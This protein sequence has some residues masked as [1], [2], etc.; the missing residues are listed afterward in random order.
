MRYLALV[1]DFDNTLAADGAVSESTEEAISRLKASG[2]R[3]IIATGRLLDDLLAKWPRASIADCI[4]AENGGLIYEPSARETILLAEP[5]PSALV[6][7]LRAANGEHRL[8][9]GRTI[10]G[11]DAERA[12]DVIQVVRGLGLELQLV[13]NRQ[14]LMILPGGVNKALGVKFA[15]RRLGMSPHEAVGIGDAENDHSFLKLSECSAAVANAVPALKERVDIVTERPAGDGVAELIDS[16]VSEDLE[17]FDNRLS[18]H[19]VALGERLDGTTVWVPPYGRN[20]LVAGPSGSGKSTFVTG[21]MERLTEQFYQLCI[22][23]PEGDY[24]TLQLAVTLGDTKRVPTVDEALA[25]L[26]D[27][28]THLNLDLLGVPLADRPRYLADL[29]AAL[30]N[31]RVRTGRPHWIVIDEAHHVLPAG[32]G[33][34][35]SVLPRRLGETVLVTVRPSELARQI[36]PLIDV[37]VAVG[38]NADRTL[39]EFCLAAGRSPT[40]WDAVAAGQGDVVCWFVHGGQDPFPMKVLRGQSERLRHRRKYAEGDLGYKSFVFRGP[41]GSLKLKAQNLALFCQIAEGV[42]DATWQYHLRNGDYSHWFGKAVKNPELAAVVKDIER[43][44]DLAPARSRELVRAE[45][46]ARY[47]LPA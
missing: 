5:V 36:L 32:S 25:V 7:A 20:V 40:R 43:Q 15:L 46:E 45:I 34:S 17:S 22:V 12:A 14:A 42:D 13:F 37:V 16:L 23:D 2:R 24:A 8:E 4:V 39:D 11:T 3:F 44:A 27:P 29:A 19:H 47:T 28:D 10:V 30:Q 9:V 6:D 1:A 38:V 21:F 18:H 33:L 41:H 26:R 35:E 31:M